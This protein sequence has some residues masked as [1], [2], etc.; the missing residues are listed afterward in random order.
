MCALVAGAQTAKEGRRRKRSAW[1]RLTTTPPQRE[2]CS[3][4]TGACEARAAAAPARWLVACVRA[5]DTL[6]IS[7][8]SS[9]ISV[10]SSCPRIVLEVPVPRDRPICPERPRCLPGA[11]ARVLGSLLPGS[12]RG[13]ARPAP[14]STGLQAFATSSGSLRPWVEAASPILLRQV[15]AAAVGWADGCGFGRCRSACPGAA[16]TRSPQG[17]GLGSRAL[18]F[19]EG[20]CWRCFCPG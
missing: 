20:E 5:P 18:G 13:P 16:S 8:G 6:P 9:S 17:L 11:L 15:G 10:S 19:A 14:W 4:P 7:P 2:I 3:S 12:L 1:R